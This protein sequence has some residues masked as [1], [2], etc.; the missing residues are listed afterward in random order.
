MNHVQTCLV[1]LYCIVIIYFALSVDNTWST[2]L[3][4]LNV[5]HKINI[6]TLSLYGP[7]EDDKYHKC[8]SNNKKSYAK[9]HGLTMYDEKDYLRAGKLLVPYNSWMTKGDL[10]WSKIQF[11]DYLLRFLIESLDNKMKPTWLLWFDEDALITNDSISPQD[12]LNLFLA[13]YKKI[14]GKDDEPTVIIA[15]DHNA[16]NI[17]VFFIKV[18]PDGLAYI[19]KIWS[20]YV[21]RAGRDWVSHF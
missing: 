18:N 11:F 1:V 4:P 21:S 9:K 16:K 13:Y 2:N 6:V 17:G 20:T 8:L 14:T 19:Q 7:S 5:V 10:R 12:K 15:E 3:Q